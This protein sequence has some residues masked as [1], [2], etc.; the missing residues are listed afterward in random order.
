MRNFVRAS[1]S[2]F[3]VLILILCTILVGS[4][5]KE[6]ILQL[7]LNNKSDV[8][9]LTMSATNETNNESYL[10]RA[11]L[12]FVKSDNYNSR[13]TR[14]IVPN[15]KLYTDS[16][17][18]GRFALDHFARSHLRLGGN[19]NRRSHM[20]GMRYLISKTC[21]SISSSRYTLTMILRWC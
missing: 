21:K 6:S 1:S 10:M 4:Q 19:T 2:T 7:A 18:L 14:S 5:G 20:R 13:I 9:R 16:G 15:E 11:L 3:H 17:R 12:P 8:D